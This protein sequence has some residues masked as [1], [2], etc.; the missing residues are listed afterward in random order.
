LQNNSALIAYHRHAA[1][2]NGEAE[3]YAMVLLNF[4]ENANQISVPFPK[5]GVWT[6]MIDSAA[7]VNVSEAG[8][9]QTISVPSHYG[10]VFVL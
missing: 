3:E 10:M 6:E 5:A 1:A 7:T 2:A 4:S 9:V 8:A